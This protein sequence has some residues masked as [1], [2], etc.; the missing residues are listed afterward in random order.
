M[1]RPVRWSSVLAVLLAVALFVPVCSNWQLRAGAATEDEL[2]DQISSLQG[3]AADLKNQM[4]E[5]NQQ[6]S[7]VKGDKAKALEQK[8]L[9][10]QQMS[11]K[12]QEIDAIQDQIDLYNQ[13]IAEETVKLGEAEEKEAQQYQ[14]FCQR[15]RAMEEAGSV[16]Y[17]SVLFSAKDF[18]EF[19]D[20]MTMIS[21]IMEYD[22]AVMDMLTAA[23]E[24]LE[25][26]KA[27]LEDSKAQQ[28]SAMEE[29]EAAKDELEKQVA[30][31]QALVAEIQ[32]KE[33]EYSSALAELEEEEEQIRKDMIR[34][35]KE[36][37]EKLA[38]GQIT[39][40][41]GTGWQWPL[42]NYFTITSLFGPRIHP[43]TGKPGNHTGTD[44]AA[45]RNTPI[46]S[47]RGGVVI[48]STYGNSYGN[49]VVVQHDNGYATLYAHMNS[50][51]VKE[52]D[53]VKQGQ[54]IGYV[55]TTGSSTGYHLH[56]EVRL[57]GTRKDA[58]NFYPAVT[59]YLKS[60]G[61]T[62]LLEH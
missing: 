54:V 43:I 30:Q 21:E 59:L 46:K 8:R 56:F 31:A 52:G 3:E 62:I 9:L 47:A 15:V 11:L 53:V 50:R 2:R 14:L 48:T 13:L 24:E 40:D 58:I 5:V 27:Q 10:D 37:E 60:G 1:K 23:R 6:L 16:S 7:S 49:Y 20:S 55:G 38:A 17:W 44:I 28:E 45:P 34:K 12:E 18:S 41:P 29:Q 4:K 26:A 32:A 51:A 22:N 57:N 19:L 39:F 42:D 35:Q 33:N 25:T 61:K 36:L